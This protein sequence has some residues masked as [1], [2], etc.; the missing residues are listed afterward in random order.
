MPAAQLKVEGF[1]R[2]IA[3]LRK[4]EVDLDEL[5]DATGAAATIVLTAAQQRAP[6]RSGAL[7]GSGTKNRARRRAVIQFGSGSVPY[8][9]PIHWGWPRRHIAAQ[10]FASRAAQETEPVWVTAYLVEIFRIC[11]N[12]KGV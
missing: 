5:K 2:L 12:I 10:P 11:E 8:A 6:H 7:A 9:G 4:A 3:T 1:P